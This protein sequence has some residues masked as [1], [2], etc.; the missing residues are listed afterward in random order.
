MTW[1]SIELPWRG[2]FGAVAAALSS[3]REIA[4][5]DSGGLAPC[6]SDGGCSLLAVDPLAV[7]TQ[8]DQSR[9][10][11]RIGAGE[12]SGPDAWRLWRDAL[13]RMPRLPPAPCPLAPGWIGYIGF[14]MGRLLERIR[15]PLCGSTPLP[16]MRMALFDRAI[17]CDP[18]TRRCVA[19]C[20]PD[21]RASLGLQPEP[22]EALGEA[23]N[24][25][26]R[27]AFSPSTSSQTPACRYS[28]QAQFEQA[29]LRAK[30]H[31]AAGDVY[32]VNLAQRIAIRPIHDAL[33]AYAQLRQAN[34][35]RYGALLR[36]EAGE[37]AV[38]SV[39]PELFLR[40][41]GRDVLTSPIK[42]TRPRVGDPVADAAAARELL[43]SG[44]DAAELAMIVDLHRNDLGRVC[45]WNSIRV[46]N[47][48]RLEI[49]PTVF[50]TVADIRGT[51][52]PDRDALDLLMACFPAGSISGVPKIR[53]RHPDAANR[54]RR[55]HAL[56]R[57][58]HR[59][60]VRSSRRI[61]RD[62]C[63]SPRHSPRPASR[64]GRTTRHGFLSRYSGRGPG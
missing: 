46:E 57:R 1:Q 62:A 11:A 21:L 41:R 45:A 8:H 43:D 40:V 22:L 19:L 50:H 36:F 23:W 20:A 51:R 34:P 10:T 17:V 5:L 56:L 53:R 39:S 58:R 2:D 37:K 48:R 60:R 15:E 63:Q 27:S 13:R 26:V 59:R 44:K 18:A 31:I 33:A 61:R 16:W 64:L 35:A 14:E 9:A 54:R 30:D 28:P 24:H 29:V 52:P 32:Q 7:I 42:G 3:S 38:A 55:G 4:W 25:A 6:G 12:H 49:H 47:A